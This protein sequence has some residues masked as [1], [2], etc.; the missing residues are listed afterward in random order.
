MGSGE[1]MAEKRRRIKEKETKEKKGI[2][3]IGKY[4]YPLTIT[5]ASALEIASKVLNVY[6]TD[7]VP[8][9]A[10]AKTAGHKVNEQKGLVPGAFH[11]KLEA[12]YLSGVFKED[13]RGAQK[14]TDLARKALDPTDL[15]GSK[16]ARGEIYK[17]QIP[18]LYEIFK[19]SEGKMPPKEEFLT[20]LTKITGVGW[21]EARKHLKN[22]R[23]LYSEAKEYLSY[24]EKPGL[25]PKPSERAIG[26]GEVKMPTE[27]AIWD[28]VLDTARM[29][30]GPEKD[31]LEAYK[32]T[33]NRL[34]SLKNLERTCLA[35]KML[36]DFVGD[37]GY[38]EIKKGSKRILEALEKDL[39]VREP[40]KEKEG[41]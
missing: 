12:M 31:A 4:R 10:L 30:W 2:R 14:I 34:D 19:G 5:P 36:K 21:P 9:I 22:I 33:V 40:E 3:E 15:E 39:G 41:T 20:L 28:T 8:T 18:L 37:D 27:R 29:C 6:K 11:R 7:C 1:L 24:A 32:R 25:V 38:K 35:V 23:N 26:R 13:K 17:S 16:G